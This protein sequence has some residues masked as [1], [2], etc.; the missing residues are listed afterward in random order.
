MWMDGTA[1]KNQIKEPVSDSFSEK[2]H[3]PALAVWFDLQ[4]EPYS[5][6][7]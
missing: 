3:E 4:E 1:D 5:W 7:Y 2:K 6:C